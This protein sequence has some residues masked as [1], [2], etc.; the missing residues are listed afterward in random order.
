MHSVVTVE[1]DPV[2]VETIKSCLPKMI[3][4]EISDPG[5]MTENDLPGPSMSFDVLIVGALA[6]RIASA[7][8]GL[9]YLKNNGI[10]AW[11]NIDGDDWL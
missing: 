1:N 10:F 7:E 2:W 5:N 3:V 8:A 11:D 4:V 9:P 6:D